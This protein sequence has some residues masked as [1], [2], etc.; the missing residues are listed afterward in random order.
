MN[1]EIHFKTTIRLFTLLAL[2]F[3]GFALFANAEAVVPPPDGGYPNFTTAEGT[4][5]LRNLTSGAGNTGVGWYSLFSDSTASFNTGVGAGTLLFN[6]ADS[7]TAIGVAALLFNTSGNGNTAVGVSA[8][9][10]NTEGF[11]NTAIGKDALLSNVTGDDNTAAGFG[12]LYN[13]T[14]GFNNTATGFETLYSNTSGNENTADGRGALDNNTEG[15]RNTAVGTGALNG[16]IDGDDNTA[17]G[18]SAGS[19]IT[20]SGNVCIGS[21]VHGFAGE[22]NITRIRNVYE[23]VASDRAVYVTADG[24]IGTLSS[25][26]R[27]KEAIEPMNR[28]SET[29]F[30]LKPVTF[31]YKKAVDAASRLSFGLIAEDVAEINPELITRDKDGKPQTVRYEAVNAM[32]LN[33]FLKE[34]RKGEQQDRQIEEQEARIAN[35]QKQIQTLMAMVEEQAAQIQKVST[36]LHVNEAVPKMPNE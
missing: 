13:N 28:A 20:G 3:L 9:Q 22:S 29:L 2:A 27:Y 34:H 10:N 25:S 24:R 33:E 4:N 8:L 11:Q 23:S 19:S 5:A 35:Q 30:A 32:L 21:G 17:V 26:R 14:V 18:N 15:N 36:R 7:D 31:R 16:N 12:T 1:S 6:N